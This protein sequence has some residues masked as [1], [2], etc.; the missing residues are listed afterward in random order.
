MLSSSHWVKA[1]INSLEREAVKV[2][3]G[4]EDL[5]R[6]CAWASTLPDDFFDSSA[7]DKLE[8]LA[9]DE[10]KKGTLTFHNEASFEAALRFLVL[11][12]KRNIFRLFASVIDA[13]EKIQDKKRGVIK[14]YVEYAF[15][16]G[17]DKVAQTEANMYNRRPW[18]N[19]CAPVPALRGLLCA[20]AR[21]K[22]DTG[23]YSRDRNRR[24]RGK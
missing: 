20:G 21:R 2:E 19:K 8:A 18:R 23:Y 14:A 6:I 16:A 11:M 1:F 7:A 9:L 13:M 22:T 4:I 5:K 3:D 10:V 12:V 17:E 15:P 24:P